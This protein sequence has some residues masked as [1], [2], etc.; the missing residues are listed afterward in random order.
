MKFFKLALVALALVS[1]LAIV[2]C[3]KPE[4]KADDAKPA[5]AGGSVL[6]GG[7]APEAPAK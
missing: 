5:A 1:A 7:A 4:Q 3:S 2:G 6:G